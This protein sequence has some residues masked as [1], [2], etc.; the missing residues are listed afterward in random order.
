MSKYNCALADIRTLCNFLLKNAMAQRDVAYNQCTYPPITP[1][2]TLL[3][4]MPLYIATTE[5]KAV[6]VGHM[7][8]LRSTHSHE[9]F[10]L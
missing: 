10:F 9:E 2:R 8:Q 5:M 7:Q 6:H 3:P 4:Q 1:G